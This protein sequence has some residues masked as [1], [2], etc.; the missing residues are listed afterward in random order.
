MAQVLRL[1]YSISVLMIILLSLHYNT[2]LKSSG[3]KTQIGTQS[4]S[5]VKHLKMTGGFGGSEIP[6]PKIIVPSKG[7][8]NSHL[9]KFLMMYTCK[10]CDGRNAQMVRI[11]YCYHSSCIYSAV[12]HIIFISALPYRFLKWLIIMV[13]LFLLVNIAKINI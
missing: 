7:K 8:Q 11:T 1:T 2:A 13:W 10:I 9:E 3:I 5:S 4:R 12:T 6:K